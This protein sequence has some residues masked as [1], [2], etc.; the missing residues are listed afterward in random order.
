[1]GKIDYKGFQKYEPVAVS[2]TVLRRGQASLY[3]LIVIKIERGGAVT[4]KEAREIWITKVCRNIIDGKP[5][6]TSYFPAKDG[7][8]NWYPKNVPMS[9][10]D[11][12]FT[13]LNWLMRNIGILVIRGYLKVI[14]M[15]QLV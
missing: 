1:M 10:D 9:E 13:V 8:N 7:S 12:T 2:R 6:R 14:P 3:D 15:V 11:I 4:L 5:H